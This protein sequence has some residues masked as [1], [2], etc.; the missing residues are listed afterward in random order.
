PHPWDQMVFP[1]WIGG[2]HMIHLVRK[3]RSN[4][5]KENQKLKSPTLMDLTPK[6]HQSTLHAPRDMFQW[7]RCIVEG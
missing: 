1:T 5:R 6:L 2:S 4:G 3:I 7:V